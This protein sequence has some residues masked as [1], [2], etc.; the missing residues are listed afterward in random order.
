M[1]SSEKRKKDSLIRN[2][3]ITFSQIFWNKINRN[4]KV[5]YRII[6]YQRQSKKNEMK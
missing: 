3:F 1:I 2:L 4:F 6:S 5:I